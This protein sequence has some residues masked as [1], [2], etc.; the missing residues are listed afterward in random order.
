MVI[1][2]LIEKL[3]IFMESRILQLEDGLQL[4][5][6]SLKELQAVNVLIL[7]MTKP[8]LKTNYP[9]KIQ[10]LRIMCIVEFHLIN[11]K[12]IWKD[13]YNSYLVSTQVIKLLKT[14][15][16]DLIINDQDYSSYWNNL[17]KET[18]MK[19]SWRVKTDYVDSDLNLS[20]GYSYRTIQSSWFSNILIKHTNRNLLKTFW[21]FY[22]Y[23]H[24]DGM[25]KENTVIRSKKIKLLPTSLQKKLLQKWNH[26]HRYTYNKAI[27]IIN[28]DP[29]EPVFRNYYK[30]FGNEK[31]VN[32]CIKASSKTYYSKLELRNLIT[33]AEASSRIKWIL[34]TPKSI[35]ESAVFEAKKN[36]KSAISNLKNGNISHFTLTYKS[37][38]NKTWSYKIS[39]DS[40]KT[41][42]NKTVGIY[43]S[44]SGMRIKCTENIDSINSDSDICYDG[45]N[46]YIIIPYEKSIKRSEYTNWFIAMDPGIRKFQVGYSPDEDEHIIFGNR[47]SLNIYDKLLYV[48]YLTSKRCQMKTEKKKVLLNKLRSRILNLQKE[49][50][51]KISNFLCKNYENIYIP[52]LTK[53]NDIIKKN[54]RK[55][56]KSTVRKMV[57]LG[58]C[59]FIDRLKAKAE[60][61]TKTKINIITEEYTSQQC[62]NC[63]HLTKTT[64]EIYVCKYCHEKIDRDVLG[65]VNIL[66]KNW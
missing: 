24:V 32:Y 30:I 62:L 34:E 61:F 13:K 51:Y 53:G 36:E 23:L 22:K 54:G 33:P 65:S 35:R 59:K 58:H 57:L 3:E 63:R 64:N 29:I 60:E 14:L 2:P 10:F 1:G 50:H 44:S 12:T 42:N 7:L 19:L 41:Y 25:V 28:E 18:L 56:N 49:L 38:R 40:L 17:V 66:L 46:Y 48:D 9:W 11:K 45:L 47:S 39:H 55:I 15:V 31:D 52:K 6:L 20:N 43:E 4:I 16:Q 5:K 27:S 8:V 21:L 37:K 26:H